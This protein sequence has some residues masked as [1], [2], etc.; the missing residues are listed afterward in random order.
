MS[1]DLVKAQGNELAAYGD[2]NIAHVVG[3]TKAI[4][5]VMRAVMKDGE[6]YGVIPGTSGK[7]TLLQ[8]GAEKILMLFWLEAEFVTEHR[9][10]R[11]D[12]IMYEVKCILKHRRTG[13][14]WGEGIGACNSKEKRYQS[15]TNEKVCPKCSK[16]AIIKGKKEYGGGWL[17]WDKKGGC[18]AKF[19]ENDE[20]ITSQE[21]QT[22]KDSVYDL[23][24]TLYKM[25]C[26]RAKVS[27]VLTST[28]A[29]DTFTQDLEDLQE[30]Q[31]QYIPPKAP[32][33]PSHL[34]V[35]AT[36]G[37]EG[38]ASS[39]SSE[40]DEETGEVA[41]ELV[42][43]FKLVEEGHRKNNTYRCE[44]VPAG[45]RTRHTPQQRERMEKGLEELGIEVEDHKSSLRNKYGKETIDDLSV[46]EAD[47]YLDHLRSRWNKR[48]YKHP[49]DK[50]AAKEQRAAPEN[51]AP[52]MEAAMREP[53]SD[54]E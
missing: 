28:A 53:G 43:C 52:E 35:V 9:E 10:V 25:A 22:K 14:K 27:A 44:W 42:D 38:P 18:K 45:R 2:Y 36:P 11:D 3:Q 37:D 5:E 30:A 54:D 1:T 46:D 7:P 24:N 21:G 51:M 13:E 40:V 12:F 34:S 41:A 20:A 31:A 48:K 26:K 32:A 8:P 50:A 47:D 19:A 33:A 16:P 6:H 29:S 23:Q 49:R 39:T 17:C 4:A 15:Q